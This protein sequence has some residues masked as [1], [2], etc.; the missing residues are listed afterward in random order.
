VQKATVHTCQARQK[1]LTYFVTD[2]EKT[3]QAFNSG[4]ALHLIGTCRQDRCRKPWRDAG[5]VAIWVLYSRLCLL[6]MKV[7]E[8]N[9][10]V[11]HTRYIQL[12]FRTH[13]FFLPFDD[14]AV[15]EVV[16]EG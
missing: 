11:S 7:S 12:L 13:A 1:N 14:S 16:V 10:P 5:N 8:I 9:T 15:I 2:R 4:C 6:Y 3:R